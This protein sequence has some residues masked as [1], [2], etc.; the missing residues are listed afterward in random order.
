MNLSEFRAWFEGFTEGLEGAPNA[1]QW[2]KI[3][4]K[5]EEI[6]SDPTPWP[7][8]VDRYIYPRREIWW[9]TP[10]WGGIGHTQTIVGGTTGSMTVQTNSQDGLP[11][12]SNEAFAQLGRFDAQEIDA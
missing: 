1:K 8:F 2:K 9:N 7:I 4:K 3:Q 5:V 12:N 6:T 11:Y 10:Y